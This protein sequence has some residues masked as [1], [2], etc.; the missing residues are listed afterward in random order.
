MAEV[1]NL[2]VQR[3]VVEAG[4][5]RRYTAEL[6]GRA[7]EITEAALMS[8]G[9]PNAVCGGLPLGSTPGTKSEFLD[10]ETGEITELT[11]TVALWVRVDGRETQVL[12]HRTPEGLRLIFEQL[13][14]SESSFAGLL[15]ELWYSFAS[16]NPFW[17]GV[18]ATCAGE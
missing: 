12:G 18:P 16:L 9:L 15:Q 13:A 14:R 17:G 4:G 7:G 11:G 10:G 5:V 2:V 6:N 8:L 3:G 1:Q